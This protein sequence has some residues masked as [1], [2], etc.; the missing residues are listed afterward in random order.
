[1]F[2]TTDYLKDNGFVDTRASSLGHAM[3][4]L[5]NSV[6]ALDRPHLNRLSVHFPQ[7]IEAARAYAEI[8]GG[9]NRFDDV[10]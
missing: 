10:K 4:T 3:Q 2:R 7:L 5:F 9:L 1:M 6:A 8:E